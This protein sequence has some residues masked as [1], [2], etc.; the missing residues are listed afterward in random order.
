MDARLTCSDSFEQVMQ[1]QRHT[2][3]LSQKADAGRQMMLH[4]SYLV[5]RPIKYWAE[6]Y[7]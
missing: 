4:T 6:S 1:S 3:S 5:S 7:T 2:V